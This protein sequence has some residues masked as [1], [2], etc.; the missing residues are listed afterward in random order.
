MEDETTSMYFLVIIWLWLYIDLIYDLLHS[1]GQDFTAAQRERA[2][3]D[4]KVL[5]K[6]AL[7]PQLFKDPGCWSGRSLELTTSRVTAPCT[8]K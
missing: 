4:F 2:Q 3:E 7:S 8:T 1:T 6:G 5:F